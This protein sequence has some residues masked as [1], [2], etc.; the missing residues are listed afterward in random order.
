MNHVWHL[1]GPDM[2]KRLPGQERVTE[3]VGTPSKYLERKRERK[4]D[5]P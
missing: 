5:N 2:E 3:K 1:T 4:P